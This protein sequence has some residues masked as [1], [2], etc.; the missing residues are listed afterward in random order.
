MGDSQ[1]EGL[2]DGDDCQGIVGFADRLAAML[3]D[4]NPGL[5]YANLAIRGR[6]IRDVLD[7]Q[8][9]HSLAM[10]PD[11]VSV[12]VGMNDITQPGLQFDRALADLALVHERLAQSGATVLT[13]TFPDIEQIVPIGRVM[14]SRLHR[15]NDAITAAADRYGFR[16]VDLYHAPSMVEPDVWSADRV[17]GST[18]G[19]ILFAA[20]AAEALELPGSSHDW[21][22]PDP[23]A[24]RPMVRSR[25]YSQ[26][27][28]T[29]NMLAPWLWHHARGISSGDGRAP[30]RPSMESLSR[31]R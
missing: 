22:Y 9:P 15:A 29:K 20:A 23:G 14:S 1:T 19:H 3:D 21:A 2:W 18:K 12:C 8:L 25:A 13:T 7:D 26:L 24:E 27:L 4:L 30:K 28:W 31:S 16:L 5:R 17:H 6:R 10:C 11:L